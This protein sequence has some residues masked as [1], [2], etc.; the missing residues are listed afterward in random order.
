M[1]EA[2]QYAIDKKFVPLWL[3]FGVR[4]SKDGVTLTDDGRFVA[5]YGFIRLETRVT[6]IDGAHITSGYRWWTAIGARLSL[7]DDG[8]TFGTND[9]A[10]VCIHFREKVGSVLRRSGHSALTVT[11]ADVEGLIQA[12]DRMTRND[13]T[14]R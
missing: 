3:P 13:S 6:N 7:A 9:N 12:L 14:G 4:P 11:V 1:S 2:F 5:T 10:G 8:L